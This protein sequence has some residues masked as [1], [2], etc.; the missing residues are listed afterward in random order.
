MFIT[1]LQLS[2]IIRDAN[3][4][5]AAFVKNLRQGKCRVLSQNEMPKETESGS[6]TTSSLN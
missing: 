6:G 4:K 5:R 1:R 3:E 2:A